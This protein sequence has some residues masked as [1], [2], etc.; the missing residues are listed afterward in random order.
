MQF[1][2]DSVQFQKILLKLDCAMFRETAKKPKSYI[3]DSTTL[4]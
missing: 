4:S 2:Q 3:S 1:S